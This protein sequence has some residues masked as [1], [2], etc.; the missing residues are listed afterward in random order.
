MLGFSLTSPDLVI[1]AGSPDIVRNVY[2]DSPELLKNK[3]CSVEL[4]LE[5][6]I[7]GSD[8]KHTQKTP[9]VKFSSICQTFSKELSPESSFSLP[10]PTATKGSSENDSLPVISVNCGCTNDGVMLG[11]VSFSKDYCFA[12][13]D[14]VRTDA[15]IADEEGVSLYQT[16]RFGNSYYK[17]QLFEPGS[18]MVDLHFA[19][20]VFTNGPPGIRVFNVYIQE[21]KVNIH[22]K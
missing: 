5:N 4:S 6:G 16:A 19:E 2:G 15:I 10:P 18:Y 22:E 13:G 11:S 21:R 1:C 9:H 8:S 14:T 12:G 7:H 3:N 17:F 20:I